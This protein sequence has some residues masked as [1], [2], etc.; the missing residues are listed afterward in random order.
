M[1]DPDFAEAFDR[2][3]EQGTARVRAK[4]IES[5]DK[6]EPIEIGGDREAPELD[7]IDPQVALSLLREHERMRGGPP[8]GFGRKQGRRPRVATNAEVR[9]A[10]VK[11]L[12]AFGVR[13]GEG[14]P[15]DPARGVA[16]DRRRDGASTGSPPPR[17][18]RKR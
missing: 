4:L 6:G 15:F 16:Q 1:N 8:A 17:D 3:L 7:G 10:L 9:S 14:V 2:A 12:R 11:R 13:V 5:R 18:E